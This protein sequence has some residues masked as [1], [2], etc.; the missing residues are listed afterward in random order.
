MEAALPHMEAKQQRLSV[1]LPEN[2]L[3]VSV[4]ET[5]MVQVVNNLLNNSCKF[6]QP[7]GCISIRLAQDPGLAKLIVA[8]DGIGIA[9]DQLDAIF[10]TYVQSSKPAGSAAPGL[11]LGLSLCKA[12]VQL[13][14]GRIQA[15]SEGRGKGSEFIVSLPVSAGAAEPAH[16]DLSEEP[17]AL[18]L[19]F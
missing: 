7:G 16:R 12:L 5:R 19:T 8:D 1:S 17:T 9:P 18:R 13:H 6:T 3:E 11:G 10:Q 4:D 15:N 14:G 2:A